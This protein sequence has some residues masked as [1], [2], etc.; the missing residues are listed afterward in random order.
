[1][2][3]WLD[4]K[5][6]APKNR[7]FSWHCRSVN[8]VK[9]VLERIDYLK[10]LYIGTDYRVIDIELLDVDYDLGEYVADGGD[11]LSFIDW[12]QK[13]GY[14]FPITIHTNPKV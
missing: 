4:D 8:Q 1:M 2:K 11:P 5:E 7:G 10:Q 12:L 9:G 6:P 13:Q 14:T 3:I